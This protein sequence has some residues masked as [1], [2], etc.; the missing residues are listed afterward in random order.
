MW[1]LRSIFFLYFVHGLNGGRG[2]QQNAFINRLL[3]NTSNCPINACELIKLFSENMIKSAIVP[4]EA[5]RSTSESNLCKSHVSHFEIIST[6]FGRY[7]KRSKKQWR[8][9]RWIAK[10][11]QRFGATSQLGG[12]TDMVDW[13]WWWKYMGKMLS[14]KCVSLHDRNEKSQLLESPYKDGSSRSNYSSR[15]C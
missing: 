3:S 5:I 7:E 13:T 11:C 6:I 14:G 10:K 4:S 12:T 8:N 2:V 9:R 15:Y 1:L